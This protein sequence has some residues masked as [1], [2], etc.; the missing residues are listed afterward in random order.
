MAVPHRS[1]LPYRVAVPYQ[2]AYAVPEGYYLR[3][4]GRRHHRPLPPRTCQNAST[5]AFLSTH[6]CC[7]SP[8][9]S[10]YEA[11]R[12]G[13]SVDLTRAFFST[14]NSCLS[15]LHSIYIEGRKCEA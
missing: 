3:C 7:L 9:H 4:T 1:A 13:E 5:R 6:N 10:I 14:H 15:P 2:A 11:G 12:K 8:L